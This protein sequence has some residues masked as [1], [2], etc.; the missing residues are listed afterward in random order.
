LCFDCESLL[1]TCILES[2]CLLRGTSCI[3]L[4]PCRFTSVLRKLK[5]KLCV[6]TWCTW[7]RQRVLFKFSLMFCQNKTH[8]SCKN[9][10]QVLLE[11]PC[12]Y[13]HQVTLKIST[14]TINQHKLELNVLK[15]LVEL[16]THLYPSPCTTY[17]L[18]KIIIPYFK[19]PTLNAHTLFLR[20]ILISSI[21][22]WVFHVFS[23][24]T[25]EFRTNFVCTY[26][27]PH[28]ILHGP[29]NK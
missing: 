13:W 7:S 8:K 19:N 25:S 12:Q 20:S 18:E 23:S 17:L 9:K 4:M 10:P 27:V 21:C 16:L 11:E 6:T 29:S 15:G 14:F 22:A 3:F 26:H 2:V 5:R 28:V 24:F 1:L